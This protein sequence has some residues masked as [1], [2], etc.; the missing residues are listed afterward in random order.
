MPLEQMA[1]RVEIAATFRNRRPCERNRARSQVVESG[2][3]CCGIAGTYGLKKEKYDIAQ[4]VGQPLF[5]MVKEIEE[6]IAVCD[7]ETCRWQ[8]E[9]GSGVKT[10]HP[11]WL[12]HKAY[13]LS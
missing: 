4:A 11:I 3:A 5:D 9:Q 2:R 10:V 6:G 13:G 1:A 8:I 12:V 7:T